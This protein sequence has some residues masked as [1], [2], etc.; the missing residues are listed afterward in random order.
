MSFADYYR[1]FGTYTDMKSKEYRRRL[2]AIE[3]LL[4]RHMRAKGKVLDLGCGIGGFSF[5][6]EDL[7]FEVTGI[8]I[9][10]EMLN[11]AQKLAEKRGS[12]V[13]FLL[14]DARNLPFRDNSF[15]YVIF[16]DGLFHF[17]PLELNRVFYEV[18]RVLKPGGRFLLQFT[19]MRSLLR[20][21]KGTQ[22]IGKRYWISEVQPDEKEKTVLIKFSSED[23]SFWVRFNVWGKTAVEL[24]TKLYFRQLHSENISKHSYFQVYTPK[25]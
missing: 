11:T 8:D 9:S 16:I 21:L 4:V 24:L 13:E 17:N 14:G 6:L 7:G 22:I 18:A 1:A 3:P 12:K 25:K 5:L 23:D 20:E 2:E 10:E 15:D 19:D